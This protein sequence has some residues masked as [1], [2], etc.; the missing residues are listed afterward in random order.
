MPGRERRPSQ[1]QREADASHALQRSVVLSGQ[2]GCGKTCFAEA[3][4]KRPFILKTL[5]GMQRIPADCDGL[6]FDD[7]RFDAR[8]LALTP[9]Q[10]INLLDVTRASSICCRH[11]DGPI[12]CL[13]RIFTTNLMPHQI[14]PMGENDEQDLGI[15]R[16]YRCYKNIKRG[17]LYMV[18][19]SQ[20]DGLF[21]SDDEDQFFQ[22][23]SSLAGGIAA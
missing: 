3:H 9:E 10:C 1:V 12:P 5:D 21:D 14:F 8:G 22:V 4:F 13:P 2:A 20:S 17:E 19:P 16:R 18:P 23:H 15:K 6:I 7:M 11:Y